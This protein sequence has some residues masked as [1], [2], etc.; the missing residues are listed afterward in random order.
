MGS[1]TGDLTGKVTSTLDQLQRHG[2]T[3][4]HWRRLGLDREFCEAVVGEIIKLHRSMRGQAVEVTLEKGANRAGLYQELATSNH[5]HL[6]LSQE[7]VHLSGKP[8]A[9]PPPEPTGRQQIMYFTPVSYRMPLWEIEE[10][11]GKRGLESASM[12][13][14]FAVIIR[15]SELI[16]FVDNDSEG[17]VLVP[18]A[19]LNLWSPIEVGTPPILRFRKSFR[20][21]TGTVTVT[22]S[23]GEG[24]I[25]GQTYILTKEKREATT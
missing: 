8:T 1:L 14:A 7:R 23:E 19:K 13:E 10:D 4:V 24:L 11:L 12:E 17:S 21:G 18:A 2:L 16:P 5:I 25:A 3:I 9:I 20:D 6:T 15:H 22:C